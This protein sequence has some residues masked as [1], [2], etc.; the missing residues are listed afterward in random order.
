MGER[1]FMKR[2]IVLIVLMLWISMP[3]SLGLA[4]REGMT[5]EHI[6]LMNRKYNSA[7]LIFAGDLMMHM[8]TVNSV[9]YQEG[10]D[11]SR[12]FQPVTSYLRG[13][14]F[15]L[16]N[17]ETTLT[18]GG[19]YS[20]Y[21]RF[22]SPVALAR[23]IKDSFFDGVVTANNHAYDDRDEGVVAT[24]DALEEAGLV[25]TGTFRSPEE[26]E[27]LMI[28]INRVSLGITNM[29]YGINGMGPVDRTAVNLISEDLLRRDHE[30]M[31]SRGSDVEVVFFHWGSEYQFEPDS[32]QRH[33][34]AVAREIG[35]DLIIGSHPHVVQP[36]LVEEESLTVYSLG[37]FV[38][39]QRDGFKDLGMMV[40]VT[41]EKTPDG[42]VFRNVDLIP[43]WVNQRDAG[44]YNYRVIALRGDLRAHEFVD[45][46]EM[47]HIE[48]LLTK[49]R[50]L[51]P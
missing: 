37:N 46:G 2:V 31:V 23:G 45:E 6:L 9:L 4:D 34:Q 38:S 1:G 25:H 48:K 18:R 41:L 13:A 12:I 3:G 40:D 21:P 28:R 50:S 29:T 32:T 51:M 47:D 22:R 16:V 15:S 44:V 7:R 43:T 8:P 42:I 11:F 36:V 33:L 49:F 5:R 20:G 14:D 17:L 39:N 26:S 19:D 30:T 35:Y 27:P 10:G 24:L